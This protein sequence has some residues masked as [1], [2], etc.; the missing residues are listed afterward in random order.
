VASDHYRERMAKAG[1]G[2][3]EPPE[4]MEALES[5]LVGPLNQVILMKTTRDPGLEVVSSGEWL[6]VLPDLLPSHI[7]GIMNAITTPL[8]AES[9]SLSS[10]SR[11]AKE[12]PINL[13]SR[14]QSTLI[15]HA[16]AVL[17]V[18]ADE[19]DPYAELDEC[20][21]DTVS[22]AEWADRLNGEYRL[23]LTPLMLKRQPSIQGLALDLLR[24]HGRS[25]NDI[26]HVPDNPD[27]DQSIEDNSGK[28]SGGVT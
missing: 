15:R 16:S 20:G 13:L 8:L 26:S 5:L 1:I 4:A 3:I 19:I 22:L 7:E 10:G 12:E 28:M 11:L 27:T 14:I 23:E 25:I 2:S 18:N 24:Q 6:E 21:F 9:N 17:T